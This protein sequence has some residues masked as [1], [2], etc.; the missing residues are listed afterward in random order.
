M[1]KL[2]YLTLFFFIFNVFSLPL[3]EA[4]KQNNIEYIKEFLDENSINQKD[5]FLGYYG[6][7]PLHISVKAENIEIS[8]LL[9]DNGADINAQDNEGKTALHLAIILSN[10]SLVRLLAKYN[11]NLRALDYKNKEPL[12]YSFTALLS[13]NKTTTEKLNI[14]HFLLK[15][16]VSPNILLKSGIHPN[17]FNI[18]SLYPNTK[19]TNILN[20]FAFDPWKKDKMHKD[21]VEEQ[22][23]M[24]YYSR[25]LLNFKEITEKQIDQ[26]VSNYKPE[27][28]LYFKKIRINMLLCKTIGT[29]ENVNTFIGLYEFIQK[30]YPEVEIPEKYQTYYKVIS[31]LTNCCNRDNSKYI[32]LKDIK[33]RKN[34]VSK[35]LSFIKHDNQ[36]NCQK[37]NIELKNI[38][39][40]ISFLEKEYCNE[41]LKII[42]SK[43]Y[44]SLLLSELDL[45]TA[46]KITSYL[47]E[48]EIKD[49]L[50]K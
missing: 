18:I 3:H 36:E 23:F 6:D 29:L 42:K 15:S 45:N 11:A 33:E 21:G 34:L 39:E 27:S 25:E 30:K 35:L 49:I 48:K 41:I 12:A 10:E 17:N 9:L 4:I 16:G 7:T 14:L 32:V 1:Q 13:N 44:I 40:S 28:K 20:E 24:D 2:L 22:I 31:N 26:P 50:S 19:L 46:N 38:K 5:G 43:N 37:D 47:T 8:K